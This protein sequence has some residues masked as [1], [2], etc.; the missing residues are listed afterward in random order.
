MLPKIPVKPVNKCSYFLLTVLSIVLVNCGGT[1]ILK[2]PV[3]FVL[4]QSLAT[5]ANMDLAV[6]LDWVIVRDGPGTW[7]RN[8]DWD[9]YL[10]RLENLTATDIQITDIAVYDSTSVRQQT[11]GSRKTLVDASRINAKR[12][13]SQ[14][15]QI[16]AG[17]GSE[18]LMAAGM[19]GGIAALNAGGAVLYMSSAAAAT[20]LGV[21][22]AAPALV[23][24]GVVKS[25][26]QNR[27]N[28]QIILRQAMLPLTVGPDVPLGLN[29]FY[30]LSPSPLS[31]EVIYLVAD[32]P[33]QQILKL[34]IST[35]LAGLHLSP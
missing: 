27:V 10:V 1:K 29:L 14:G 33:A 34:D 6:T 18:A 8:A 16:K 3:P 30:P 35:P 19:V 22:I 17:L 5:T 31:L 32:D 13:K 2:D 20:T 9:E 7:A 24:G 23:A 12:Y 4:E 26:N 15:V 21:L 11:A 28:D 25:V